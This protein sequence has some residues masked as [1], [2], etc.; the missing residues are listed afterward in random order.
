[1]CL[2]AL[3][4]QP[5]I[6]Q[7][8][9]GIF[10]HV[11]YLNVW[12]F[13]YQSLKSVRRVFGHFCCATAPFFPIFQLKLNLKSLISC[14]QFPDH[15]KSHP[16][17]RLT[18]KTCVCLR[19]HMLEPHYGHYLYRHGH[20]EYFCFWSLCWFAVTPAATNHILFIQNIFMVCLC[21]L[22]KCSKTF[23][24]KDT[25]PKHTEH[26]FLHSYQF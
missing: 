4:Y 24:K 14:V 25:M 9:Q 5:Q 26:F 2:R 13:L 1:M 6:Y 18:A 17:Q 20:P 7:W 11:F 22:V 21:N 19:A 8:L 12:N 23:I 16:Q 15:K 10:F 3:H